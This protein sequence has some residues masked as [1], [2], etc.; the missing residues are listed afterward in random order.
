MVLANCKK[1]HSREAKDKGYSTDASVDARYRVV[2]MDDEIFKFFM[3]PSG[4]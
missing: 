1:Y 4:R 3:D 2:I